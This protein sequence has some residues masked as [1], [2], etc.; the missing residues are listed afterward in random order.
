MPANKKFWK[1][2]FPIVLLTIVVAVC[3]SLLSYIDSITREKISAQEDEAVKTLITD[4]FPDM[5]RYEFK[6]DIYTVYS[7]DTKLGYAF[8]ATGKG[9]GG[10]ISILVGLSDETTVK[11]IKIVSQTE[12]PGLGSRISEPFFTDQFAGVDINDIALSRNGGKIDAITGSTISSSAVVE[13][14]RDTA[15]EKVKQLEGSD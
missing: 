10:D 11:G 13:A 12:T 14:V 2:A 4:I 7:D 8:L 15:M 1:Q 6:N 5:S 3:V 9:Y